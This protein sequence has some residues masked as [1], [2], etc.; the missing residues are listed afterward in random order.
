[1]D[2]FDLIVVAERTKTVAA[3]RAI[4]LAAGDKTKAWETAGTGVFWLLKR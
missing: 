4:S 1:V 2:R 3:A